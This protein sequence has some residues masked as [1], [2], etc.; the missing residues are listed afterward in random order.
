MV[1]KSTILF[2]IL[3]VVLLFTFSMTSCKEN[4]DKDVANNEHDVQNKTL[5]KKQLEMSGV[6]KI[7]DIFTLSEQTKYREAAQQ[8]ILID[9]G[10]V[11]SKTNNQNLLS[12]P[13]IRSV[14]NLTN[15]VL[16]IVEKKI[17]NNENEEGV[18][19]LESLLKLGEFISEEWKGEEPL[20]MTGITIQKISLRKLVVH[21]ENTGEEKKLKQTRESLLQLQ[22]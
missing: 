19:I 7:H 11:S 21:Y 18:R 4:N 17:L 8:L 10:E 14:K 6:V 12:P 20:K 15:E 16:N 1:L 2:C 22:Q 5:P 13:D 3:S 9:W